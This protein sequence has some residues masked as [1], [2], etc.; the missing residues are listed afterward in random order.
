M[1]EQNRMW[2][3][4]LVVFL[5]AGAVWALYPPEAK[6]KP[7]IDLAGGTSLIYEFDT[8]GMRANDKIGLAERAM[9]ILKSRVDPNSQFNLI[10]RPIGNNRLEIQMPRPPKHARERR[11]AYEAARGKVKARNLT[12]LEVEQA[13][14]STENRESAMKA[15]VR[16]VEGREEKLQATAAAWDAYLAA[17]AGGDIAAE[18]TAQDTYGEAIDAALATN[19]R[20]GRLTDVVSLRKR[21]LRDEELT[22]LR[23]AYPAYVEDIDSTL[24]AFNV[25]TAGGKGSLE[26]PADLKRLLRGAGVLEFRILAE[27]DL[28]DPSKLTDPSNISMKESIAKY[29]EQLS[30]RGPRPRAGDNYEWYEIDDFVPFMQAKTMEEAERVIPTGTAVIEKYAGKFYVLAYADDGSATY[31]L[32]QNS[33]DW[34]LKRASVS[35]DMARNTP[36]VNF[37]L[38][39][40]GGSQFAQVTKY[41][42][43]RQLAILLDGHA[44]SHA[45]INTVIG[46]SGEISGDFTLQRVRDIVKKLEA[47][48]LPARLKETPLQEKNTGPSLGEK[49]R[50]MGMKAA[51]GGLLSV[52]VFMLAYYWFAGVLA[53]IALILNILFVLAVMA[54]MEATFTL[55]GIAGLLL[56]VGM[57]VDANVLIFERI[58]EELDRDVT[59][60]KAV[61]AGYEKAF[62]TIV[63]ANLTTLITCVIL[64]YVGSEE[65]QGFAMTLG[66]G[67]VTSMF[68]AL[69]VTRLI[70]TSLMDIGVVKSLKMMNLIRRPNIDWIAMRRMFWPVSSVSVILGLG[71]F[72]WVGSTNKEEIFD[73]EFLG[74]TSIQI[75]LAD[76]VEMTAEDARNAMTGK[77]D[78]AGKGATDWLNNAADA[79]KN[80][81]VSAG[82]RAGEFIVKADGLKPA[83]IN[84]LL[85][86]TFEDHLAL[87]G[88]SVSGGAASFV[89]KATS[90][91]IDST[92]GEEDS[93]AIEDVVV[94]MET[95]KKGL[96]EAADYTKFAVKRLSSA[97][98]QTV[99]DVG[100]HTSEGHAFEVVTVEPNKE[101]V[102]A[103]I[104]GSLGDKLKVMRPVSFTLV[105]DDQLAPT[106]M[107]PIREDSD[108][109]GQVI[110]NDSPNDIRAY[111]GGVALVF[112]QLAPPQSM[113]EINQRFR[114]MRLQ[115]QFEKYD[116]RDY[117]VFGLASTGG[118]TGG[119]EKFSK[120]ALVV[121]D[122]SLLYSDDATKWEDLLAKPE[123]EQATEALSAEKSLRKVVQF[124]PQMASQ[125]QQRA[126]ISLVLALGAIVAYVWI[127]FGTMQY[128]LAAIVALVHDVSITLG[129]ITLADTLGI[130]DFRIDL[131]MIAAL[132]TVVGYSLNDTIV[133]FDRIRE[134]RGK[135][136]KLSSN[137]INNSINMTLSRT[138]LTSMTTLLAV[139][140]LFFW[141]GPGVHGFSFALLCGVIVGTYSS[142]GIAAPMLQNPRLLHT[143]IY[144]LI[145]VGV[146]GVAFVS[147]DNRTF[148]AVVSVIMVVLLFFAIRTERK[149]GAPAP[150][151]A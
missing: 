6:L 22:K 145:C 5:T 43:K 118:G 3:W 45:T 24:D 59:L 27:R 94:D 76:G 130:G 2:K 25:W 149:A 84:V 132:L 128:G 88:F 72:V 60:R 57:A 8:T 39:P 121:V 99:S 51:F 54:T 126:I 20:L 65:V 86:T 46:Q 30:K 143:V 42:L 144:V 150:A 47:G 12:R 34:E 73:I 133:V 23:E 1:K 36:T 41:N 17:R 85:R 77:K 79:L 95:F 123:F 135:L 91:E 31:G 15:L 120:I 67:I 83:E 11:E 127:R 7:G 131:A 29:T 16:G 70:L 112:D 139:V 90:K 48:S 125:T 44:I 92:D 102:R 136:N 19:L 98:I 115:P 138:L 122:E 68:T 35:K 101:L 61:K 114:E 110:G 9:E 33:Q 129:V 141:G 62:S 100:A 80:A 151:L 108:F 82:S 140:F 116:A 96:A 14:A 117:T 71:A 4:G 147:V 10:W 13:L 32:T 104:I 28:S 134:N 111:K 18:L 49:N 89:T 93:D 75:D 56:T 103:A 78:Y 63:D 21:K 66:F 142:I 38:D 146:I 64:G 106:G 107:Y 50:E 74:G 55:P 40:R 119:E 37:V 97:R 58:R 26:D 124:A 137:M 113:K 53:D 109:L 69:F 52:V 81:T 148:V 87:G 105:T